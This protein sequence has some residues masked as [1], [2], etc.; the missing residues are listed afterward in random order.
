MKKSSPK[1]LRY[2][3]FNKPYGVLCQFTDKEGTKTL[4]DYRPFPNDVYPAG[5]LDADS[6]GLVLLTNDGLL[7]HFLIEPRY[8]HPRTYLVQVE[9]SPTGEVINCLRAGVIIERRKTLPAEVQLLSQE[10]ILPPRSVPIRSRKTVPTAWLKITL[11][12][13]RNRQVKKMTSAVGHPTLRLVRIAIGPLTLGALKPGE[14]REL[15]EKE[16]EKL[17]QFIHV[18]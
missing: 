2:I 3:L 10:P 5:R 7:K 4:G 18:Q 1:K 13:G 12:E 8:Q 9:H 14:S 15:S 11:R 16:V 17:R 6:E